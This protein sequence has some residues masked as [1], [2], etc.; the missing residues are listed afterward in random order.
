MAYEQPVLP[1]SLGSIPERRVPLQ[2]PH[3]RD[4]RILSID[5]G[6]I[7]GI[8]AA[9]VLA[10]LEASLG[11]AASIADHFDLAAGTS[12][13][14]IIAL[15]LGAGKT[16]AEIRDLYL[17]RGPHIFPPVW[18]NALGRA[19]KWV[20]N[21]LINIGFN[22]HDRKKLELVL[23]EFLKDKLLGELKLRHVIPAFDGRFSEVFLY[24]TCHHP[25]YT[26]DWRRKMVEVAMA[27]SAA[28][29][30]YRALEAGGYRLIDGGVW[31]N[32]PIMLAI[33]EAM[34]AYDPPRERIK[35]LSIGCGDDPFYVTRRMA[36][37]GFWQW[38]NVI[39]AAVRAQSLAATNQAKL[40]LG[41]KNV[42][43][44]EP[45]I[46]AAPIE[47]DDYRRAVN[48]LLPAVSGAVAAHRERVHTMFLSE[49]AERFRANQL[50]RVSTS[51]GEQRRAPGS[52]LAGPQR[53][54]LRGRLGAS[55]N[56][57]VFF[58]QVDQGNRRLASG[59]RG[60][61]Q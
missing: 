53:G 11:A 26:R 55:A 42:V 21:N 32:N 4:F 57:T 59:E 29:T 47:M 46:S 30:T 35:V 49:K 24:K 16:A 38:R 18:D 48:E 34:V 50:T 44:I 45:A 14:G 36:I 58:P 39:A 31:A 10:D 52:W 7:R 1:R 23:Q 19:W 27:T 20:R 6:G 43:R 12:T 2:W 51:T 56:G 22:R 15:G 41:P 8:F 54:R 25:D 37:G 5:G 40:L 33:V 3:N 28:P 13:G 61:A 9:G 17:D 60:E